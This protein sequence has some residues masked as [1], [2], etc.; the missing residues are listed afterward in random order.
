VLAST[1][2]GARV[3]TGTTPPA[4]P[5]GPPARPTAISARFA[6]QYAIDHT[7]IDQA[8]IDRLLERFEPAEVFRLATAFGVVDRILRVCRLLDVRREEVPA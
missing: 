5:T 3:A 8:E 1:G 4:S 2:S 7:A 6:E